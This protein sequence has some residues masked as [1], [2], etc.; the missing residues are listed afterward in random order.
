MKTTLT[1]KE[2][3]E[4]ADPMLPKDKNKFFDIIETVTELSPIEILSIK[5]GGTKLQRVRRDVLRYV[6]NHSFRMTKTDI[7]RLT[8]M[9]HIGPVKGVQYVLDNMDDPQVV[10]ETYRLLSPFID[11]DLLNHKIKEYESKIVTIKK[12]IKLKEIYDE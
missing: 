2:I 12:L 7:G 5:N 1:V 4:K 6:L 9:S 3:L 11:V 10:K 8:G